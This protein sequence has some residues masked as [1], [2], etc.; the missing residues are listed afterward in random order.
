MKRI[1]KRIRTAVLLLM[2]PLLGGCWDRTEVNDLALIMAASLDA[3]KNGTIELSVQ[4][5]TPNQTSGG[6]SGISSSDA[7]SDTFIVQSASGTDFADASSRLQELLPRKVFWGHGEVFVFGEQLAKKGIIDQMDF[8][9]R[10]PQPRERAYVFISKGKAK[11]ILSMNTRIERDSAE[12]LREMATLSVGTG[13]S[14]RDLN[15][16]L[17]GR[18]KAAMVPVIEK[19]EGPDGNVFPYISGAAVLKE[20][21]MTAQFSDMLK[22]ETQLIRGELKVINVTFPVKENKGR[23]D[24]LMSVRVVKCRTK[25]IPRI[26]RNRWSVT[27]RVEGE[28][29]VLQNA[30]RANVMKPAELPRLEAQLNQEIGQRIESA[31]RLIQRE[32]KAD[33]FGV[34]DAFWR[35]YPKQW[36]KEQKRW[37]EIF[38]EIDIHAEAN[39]KILWPGFSGKSF[40]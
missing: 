23:E 28:G 35:K 22:R 6:G 40:K 7:G 27:V 15:D 4:V 31:F 24:G 17:T 34:A 14:L 26:D 11:D 1:G 19:K 38:P 30:S 18:A 3:G 33:V 32:A 5:F 16:M 29:G 21:K 36:T 9:F 20:G 2:T 37:N 13:V 25:L 12:T 8:L 10:H 39:V